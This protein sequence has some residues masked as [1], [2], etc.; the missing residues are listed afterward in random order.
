[1]GDAVGVVRIDDVW[2]LSRVRRLYV[3]AAMAHIAFEGRILCAFDSGRG[4]RWMVKGCCD[5]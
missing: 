1:M 3:L 2:P 4:T 5:K